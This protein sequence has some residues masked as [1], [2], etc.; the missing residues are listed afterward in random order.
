M[1]KEAELVR[2]KW[3]EGADGMFEKDFF[4]ELG[5]MG[6][7]IASEVNQEVAGLAAEFEA[8]IAPNLQKMGEQFAQKANEAANKARAMADEFAARERAAA[9]RRA[10]QSS[11]PPAKEKAAAEADNA[12][13]Q[14]RILKMVEKGVITP[15]EA[16]L[17]LEALEGN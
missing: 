15:E 6:A 4:S 11:P 16:N 17:L 2:P 10:E 13:E 5:A 7:Q 1:L 8:N 12:V 9:E 3:F 14:L